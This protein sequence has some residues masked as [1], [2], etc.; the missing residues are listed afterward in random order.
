MVSACVVY[1]SG[2]LLVTIIACLFNVS[3]FSVLSYAQLNDSLAAPFARAVA[4]NAFPELFVGI[5][6]VMASLCCA[7]TVQG[8]MMSVSRIVYSSAARGD[9]PSVFAKL[10][11]K[12]QIP[13][14]AVA[15]FAAWTSLVLLP[16]EET[17]LIVT[18]HTIG[19]W[20]FFVMVAIALIRLRSLEPNVHR[21]YKVNL[22]RWLR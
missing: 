7:G 19:Q 21:P 13:I 20:F 11:E 16:T 12:K 15:A 3:F 2:M 6:S 22:G 5:I 14:N 9:F 8:W 18:F 17:T 10:S 4:G 1:S